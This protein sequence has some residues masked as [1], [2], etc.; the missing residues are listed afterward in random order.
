MTKGGDGTGDGTTRWRCREQDG[1]R[2]K[3]DTAVQ[4]ARSRRTG[5]RRCRTG[6]QQCRTRSKGQDVGGAEWQDTHTEPRRR[7]KGKRLVVNNIKKDK[8]TKLSTCVR[9]EGVDED[10]GVLVALEK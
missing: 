10:R 1:G 7:S 6:T 4:E 5:T 8:F 9:V 2:N 3:R